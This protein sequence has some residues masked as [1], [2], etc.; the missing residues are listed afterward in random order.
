MGPAE[1]RLG[2]D[3]PRTRGQLET[4]R[5]R[6]VL[7]ANGHHW[8]PRWPEPAFPGP[9]VQGEQMHAHD[10]REPEGFEGKRVL[11]LGIGNSATDIAV[12]AS[13]IAARPT[14][15]CAAAPTCCRST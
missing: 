11:V 9:R 13:R 5:Y 6:A 14:S 2:R 1:R 4:H 3:D 15:R 8:D 12:E 10:Y 7:V